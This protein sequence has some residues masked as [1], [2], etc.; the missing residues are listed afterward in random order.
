MLSI[1]K[2]TP[3][4]ADYYVDQL[5][6]G[7]DEYYLAGEQDGTARWLGQAA[8]RLGLDGPVTPEDFRRILDGCHP[9]RNEP[10]GVP[11]TTARRVAGFDLCFSAPK[12]VSV[13]WALGGPDLAAAVASAHDR[14]VT[15]AVAALEAETVRA[16]RGAGGSRLEETG[17]VAAAAFAHRSS[18]AGDPQI[19]THVVVAN[20]TPDGEGRWT[21]LYGARVYRWAKT[22]GYIYQAELRAE[23]TRRLGVSWTPVRNGMADIEGIP[24]EA[25]RHFSTRRVQIENALAHAGATSAVAA[26]TATLATRPAKHT[27]ADLATLRHQWAARAA[28]LGIDADLVPALVG[29]PRSPGIEPESLLSELTGPSGL[30]R[31]ASSFDRRDVLQSLAAASPDGA[32]AGHLRAGADRILVDSEI[33]ALDQ[34]GPAGPR[35]TTTELLGVEARLLRRAQTTSRSSRPV[36]AEHLHAVLAQRPSLSE[37]QKE[38]VERLVASEAA[39]QVVIGRAGTGK[40]FAL[41][42]ARAAWETAGRP[43]IGAALAARAAAEL[44][45]GA[46]IASTTVDR[47]LA[48]IDRPGPLSGLAPHTVLVLDEAGMI[49][50]RKLARLVD[51]AIDRNATVVLVGD[52]RQL[53]EIEAGGALA[54]LAARVPVIELTHNRRQNQEWERHALAELR[55]GSVPAAVDAYLSH[56]RISLASTAEAAREQMVTDW[57]MARNGGE[58][59]AMYAL[60]RA[61]VDDLNQRARRR[62]HDAGRLGPD[63]LDIAGRQFAVGDQVICLRND[64]RLGVRNGTTATIAELHPGTGDITLDDGTRLPNHYLTDGHLSHGYATTIHKAQGATV[65]RALLLGSDALYREAGYVGLSRARQRSD[66]YLVATTAL[67][68][69]PADP[70]ANLRRDLQQRRSEPLALDQLDPPRRAQIQVRHLDP[71]REALLADPPAWLTD[72]LGPPPLTGTDRD[73]W[74]SRAARLDA[75]RHIY[76]IDSPDALGPRPRDPDQLRAWE[77]G[78]LAIHEQSRTLEL[79]Q[80][81]SL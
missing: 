65:D 26:Q 73:S 75:Y 70:L 45:G 62:L 42:A 54:G 41:D 47:L 24:A 22:I 78:Q 58:A 77:L 69:D 33:V 34:P 76:D 7:A 56:G 36:T 67:E 30:T 23:L 4:R 21:S 35:Y 19:H 55:A 64:R 1:G 27:V 16:R 10:L 60:R 59:V 49:G 28:E 20:L 8:G 25:C 80:G 31:N 15:S 61:D 9:G 2:L 17:G 46:G 29:R 5:P 63:Q 57:W 48:D 13:M 38:M 12:S 18:R 43:V 50:T 40:T 74:A 81:L 53:P 68:P 37:E 3:G 71:V 11:N 51:H 6:I 79:D 44:Q 66:L 14:A 39:V 72:A 32:D 52:H